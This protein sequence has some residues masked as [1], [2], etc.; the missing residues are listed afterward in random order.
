MRDGVLARWN[1]LPTDEAEYE[2][3]TLLRFAAMGAAN[4]DRG[5]RLRMKR[6]CWRQRK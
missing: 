3:L 1:R 4:G 5:G 2:I 6:N